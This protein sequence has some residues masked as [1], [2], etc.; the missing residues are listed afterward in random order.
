MLCFAVVSFIEE[1]KEKE[2][3]QM[4]D[5]VAR[6]LL[7]DFPYERT[8]KELKNLVEKIRSIKRVYPSCPAC[9]SFLV[10]RR[11]QFGE[12][13]GCAKYPKCKYTKNL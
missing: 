1:A 10:K 13:W 3:Q 12:F 2:R 11:G 4:R 8:K 7:A 9:G 5:S 6:K